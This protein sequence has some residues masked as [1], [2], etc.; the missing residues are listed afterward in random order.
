MPPMPPLPVAV[1][2]V[3]APLWSQL[4]DWLSACF[5][6]RARTRAPNHLLVQ[7]QPRLDLRAVE[8]ACAGYHHQGGPGAPARHPV[9]CLVRALL[10]GALYDY[11][12]RELEEQIAVNAVVCWFVG[13]SP[14]DSTPDHT[15]LA[16]FYDWVCDHQRRSY[17]DSVLS[18]I[19]AALPAARSPVQFGDTFA[20]VA[21]GAR[22]DVRQLLRRTARNWLRRLRTAD[23]AAHARLADQFQASG[24][25]GADDEP[26]RLD[27]AAYAAL[28]LS[29]ARA[30]DHCAALM[31]AYLA[32]APT[33]PVPSQRTLT[34]LAQQLRK[35]LADEFV[36]TRDAAG[37]LTAVTRRPA[38]ERGAYRLG[39]ATD[40][41]ATYR[42]HG[43]EAA[44]TT[45]G[46]NTEVLADAVFV[47]EIAAATGAT[48]DATHLPDLLTAEQQYHALCPDKVI[49]DAA[50]GR[51]KTYAAVAAATA[52]QTQLVAPLS[53]AGTRYAFGPED[54]TLAPDDTTLTCPNGVTSQI[55][56]R[57]ESHADGRFFRFYASQCQGC[58]LW[59]PCRGSPPPDPAAGPPAGKAA[60]PG[61]RRVFIS[62]YRDQVS[63]ARTYQ[64]TA[65]Y[66]Q[67]RRQRSTI[68]RII[69]ALTRYNGARQ[70]RRRGLAHADFQAKMAATAYNIKKWLRSLAQRDRQ[71]AAAAA[72]A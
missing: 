63:Q 4:V 56:Y 64:Q 1:W 34:D 71:A 28:V 43:P 5:Y 7:L 68:E 33:L 70:C 31:T 22:H 48:P 60:K 27:E 24:L 39:S 8:Q 55:A 45:L 52:K 61:Y 65:A 37:Q 6:A 36:L 46:Y 42:V 30:A 18:Q 9:A 53:H 72:A 29:T 11:S 20:Q 17:F 26:R 38:T 67:D 62:D 25:W 19:D 54:F 12:L 51:G 32:Q 49:Y 13:Y 47:R 44:K 3:L 66:Q 23:A 40:P 10:V 35:I 16:R 14:W 59:E 58:P 2:L 50:A 57:N 15:T 41:D 69:A 21:R